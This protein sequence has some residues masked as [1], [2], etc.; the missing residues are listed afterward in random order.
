MGGKKT[1]VIKLIISS[2]FM[3]IRHNHVTISCRMNILQKFYYF[4]CHIEIYYPE[5]E[6]ILLFSTKK[7]YKKS[8][9]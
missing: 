8:K 6:S 7:S 1:I 2:L 4:I 5:I 3:H 9:V